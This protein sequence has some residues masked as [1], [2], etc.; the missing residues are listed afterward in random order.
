MNYSFWEK[1][2]IEDPTDITIIGSGIVGLST[3]L[4]IKEKHPYASIKI[5][6]R[7][8]LP[9]GASTKNAGFACFG[10][11]SELQSDLDTYGEEIMLRI[12]KMRFEGLKKLLKRVDTSMMEY[13]QVGGYE[14]FDTEDQDK[15]DHYRQEL[16]RW[17]ERI[18][19]Y[20]GLE[21]CFS[22][23]SHTF[24]QGLANVA[25]YNKYE[26][27]LQPAKMMD[28]L[29]KQCAT[30][31]ISIFFGINV[32]SIDQPNH[33][34]ATADGLCINYKKLII[35]TNGF[36]KS[37]IN[38]LEVYP[39][40]NQVLITVPFNG[41]LPEGG[42]HLDQGYIYF[43]KYGQRI[44][45]GGCRNKGGDEE[46]TDLFGNTDRIMGNLE[47]ILHKLFPNNTPKIE[48]TWSGILGIGKSKEPIVR[49]IEKDILVGVRL[50]GMG[51]AI[52]SF[53]G[54]VLATKILE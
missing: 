45:L 51:V 22:M 15:L 16:P 3:A 9:Y 36:T 8:H 48:H 52:G 28:S 39:A 47:E 6:E 10:S 46:N 13:V 53:L 49:Y 32:L 29:I 30:L 7:G 37:L 17:N 21:A 25:I 2:I 44:L 35:C 31:G 5:I 50:G 18:A 38:D 4:S 23:V 54:E 43:R 14:V 1:K 42:Y 40:R 20:I 11:I 33:K 41:N 27:L 34:L 24:F 12:I 26:G 19:D